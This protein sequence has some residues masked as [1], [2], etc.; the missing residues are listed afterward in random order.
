MG[1]DA[2][3][4]LSG[5]KNGYIN[6][7]NTKMLTTKQ[8]ATFV[9]TFILILIYLLNTFIP[10]HFENLDLSQTAFS[11]YSSGYIFILLAIIIFINKDNLFQIHVDPF[12]YILFIITGVIFLWL[13]WGSILSLFIFITVLILFEAFR[14]KKVNFGNTNLSR[15]V[16]FSLIATAPYLFFIFISSATL[17][18]LDLQK[19]IYII[20]YSLITVSFW[21]LVFRGAIWSLL[22]INSS[23]TEKTFVVQL[24]AFW[25][26]FSLRPTYNI[27]FFLIVPLLIGIW[28]SFL[29]MYTKSITPAIIAYS[30]LIIVLK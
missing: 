6:M 18:E 25:L 16:F 1:R 7:E 10:I 21:E 27:S 5:A 11:Y 23:S 9:I 28:H 14:S 13:I 19:Q 22:E 24:L 20:S 4:A 30:I 2:I 17:E 12:F 26:I 8:A 15:T 29:V 3:I